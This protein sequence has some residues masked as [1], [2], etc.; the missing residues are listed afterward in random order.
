MSEFA[1]NL[2]AVMEAKGYQQQD[3]A[4]LANVTPSAV[5]QW[6][7]GTTVPRRSRI[8][9]LAQLLAVPPEAL[10]SGELSSPP[11]D[12]HTLRAL[13][14]ARDYARNLPIYAAAEAGGGAMADPAI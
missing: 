5:S 7:A 10:S 9:H 11:P 14:V 12:I 4:R 8:L 1:V 2:R 6:L 3:V 13:P